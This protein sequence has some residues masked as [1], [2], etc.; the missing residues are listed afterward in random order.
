MIF[1]EMPAVGL[2]PEQS[3]LQEEVEFLFED[4][5]NWRDILQTIER[6]HSAKIIKTIAVSSTIT[7]PG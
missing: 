4:F 7:S 5:C 6:T 3:P 2:H 1:D